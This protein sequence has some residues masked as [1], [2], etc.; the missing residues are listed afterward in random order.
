MEIF[1]MI[2]DE[3]AAMKRHRPEDFINFSRA[4]DILDRE[5]VMGIVVDGNTFW[6]ERSQLSEITDQAH[7][8]LVSYI[9]RKGYKYLYHT[10]EGVLNGK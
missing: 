3:L 10:K 1:G 5:Q 8:E 9:E 2:Y 7:A 4:F 6:L